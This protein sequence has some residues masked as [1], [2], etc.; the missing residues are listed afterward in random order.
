VFASASVFISSKDPSMLSPA[1]SGIFYFRMEDRTACP[2][3][4]GGCSIHTV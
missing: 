4:E 2:V 1:I 3:R